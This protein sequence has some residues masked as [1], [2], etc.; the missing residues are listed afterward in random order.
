MAKPI[1]L[2]FIGAGGIAN[3]HADALKKVP[4]AT[5]VA[6]TDVDEA[7]LQKF[8]EKTG[9]KP[10]ADIE[11]MFGESSLDA[12]Y[13]V[14][15]PF[16]HGKAELAVPESGLPFFV[17]KPVA[18]DGGFAKEISEE[19]KRRDVMTS[20]GYMNRYRAG[21]QKARELLSGEPAVMAFG[22]W[23]GGTPHG[24][25]WFG[26][27]SK[28][29]G[30]FHEQVTHTVDLVRYFLGEPVEVYAAAARGFV[31]GVEG[32]TSDDGLTVALRFADGAVANLMASLSSNAGGEVF[33]NVHSV[34]RNFR[35]TNW[36]HNLLLQ[37]RG[38]DPTTIT[39]EPN[40]FVIED[41]AFVQAV[42]TGDRSLIRCDYPD[43]VK[44]ALVSLAA[45]RS[46]DTGVPVSLQ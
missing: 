19:V 22:G 28:S 21:V 18:L 2:G 8:A 24:G 23:F 37:E 15:P 7:A 43:G 31:T 25:H 12:V 40:I 33:L 9:G 39:G 35:F 1:Q 6:V 11:S 29:G 17:E 16:A 3:A 42:Q 32:Y 46:A 41:A 14:V 36:E 4:D 5:I 45:N 10:F 44:S 26:D 38:K 30:Q 13:I 27:R 34:N 20:V